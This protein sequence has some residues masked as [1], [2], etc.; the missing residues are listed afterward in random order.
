MS[1][2]IPGRAQD[3]D[4]KAKKECD[5]SGRVVAEAPVDRR[6]PQVRNFADGRVVILPYGSS[7]G[8]MTNPRV[9][10]TRDN[11]EQ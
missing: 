5:V 9:C 10:Q 7:T 8:C 2:V 11:I 1:V 4:G 6:D 3:D